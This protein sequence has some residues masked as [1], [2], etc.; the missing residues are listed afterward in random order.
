MGACARVGLLPGRPVGPEGQ[1]RM[2]FNE[3]SFSGGWIFGD[4]G[5]LLLLLAD[6]YSRTITNITTEAQS[7]QRTNGRRRLLLRRKTQR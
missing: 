4:D 3:G 2:E 6:N 5:S 1:E 7:T